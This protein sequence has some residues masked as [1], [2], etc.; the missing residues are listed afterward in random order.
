M[1]SGSG[2]NVAREMRKELRLRIVERWSLIV[3][4]VWILQIAVVIV[5]MEEGIIEGE[6]RSMSVVG[7]RTGVGEIW[8]NIVVRGVVRIKK[9][10]MVE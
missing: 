2:M 10:W 1:G 8:K 3:E 6:L 4:R 7:E 9:S 5:L